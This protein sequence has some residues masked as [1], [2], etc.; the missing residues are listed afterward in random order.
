MN[1]VGRETGIFC[2]FDDLS[3]K[4]LALTM[5]TMIDKSFLLLFDIIEN[6]RRSVKANTLI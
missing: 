6:C 3:E 2:Q 5:K 1:D 4:I